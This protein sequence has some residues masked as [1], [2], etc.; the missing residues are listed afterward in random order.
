MARKERETNGAPLL[1]QVRLCDSQW[2]DLHQE[3]ARTGQTVG[4]YLF[5]ML[6]GLGE[7][8]RL[9]AVRSGFDLL[10][11]ATKP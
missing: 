9:A 7:T 4:R 1:R 2:S 6:A 5:Y 3:A 11:K 10:A 8:Q